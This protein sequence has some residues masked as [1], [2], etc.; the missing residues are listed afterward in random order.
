MLL[1]TEA[2]D[3]LANA[4]ALADS[5]LRVLWRRSS[6]VGYQTKQSRSFWRLA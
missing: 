5:W 2:G 6:S 4:T 3:L 1:K